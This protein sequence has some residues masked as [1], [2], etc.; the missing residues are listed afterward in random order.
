MLGRTHAI[1][2]IT[3]WL[4]AVPVINAVTDTG[5]SNGQIAL[6]TALAAGAAMAPDSDHPHSSICRT[7]GPLTDLPAAVISFLAR[8][9]R[10][11]THSL[12]GIA[13]FTAG[14]YWCQQA[15][16]WARW[17]LMWVLLGVACRAL[18]I[19]V[20]RHR[21]LTAFVHAVTMA[22]V[23]S[24]IV[25]ADIDTT[26]VLPWA[27]LVGCVAHIAGDLLTERGCPLLWP[28]RTRFEFD[29]MKT[30]GWAEPVLA[31]AAAAAAVVLAVMLTPAD[32]YVIAVWKAI[33]T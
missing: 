6:G 4:A 16:G 17:L 10:N 9:H 21:S 14:A 25:A 5:L 29:L 13:A 8:G 32:V 30:A 27:M 22:G 19:A 1:T 12:L 15:G 33:T 28:I 11:G 7:Y 26:H 24:L 20:P 2:G 18:G 23:T 31:F 3:A